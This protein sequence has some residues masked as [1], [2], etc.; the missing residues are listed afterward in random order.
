MIVQQQ[1]H[2]LDVARA[3]L[4]AW[5]NHDFDAART[6]L[7][8]DVEV[9][10]TTTQPVPAATQLT[11]V[12]DYMQGLVQ[13]AQ[14]VVPGSL[15]ELAGVGDQ[16]NALLLVTVRGPFRPGGAE[17]TLAGARLYLLDEEGKIKREQVIYFVQE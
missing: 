7:A 9:T 1:S 14:A 11:R 4:E 2:A 5:S 10:V 12:D 6:S 8:S 15:R 13:F 3:H 17:T 16:R